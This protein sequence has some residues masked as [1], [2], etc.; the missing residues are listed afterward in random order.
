MMTAFII[1]RK[2]H[3]KKDSPQEEKHFPGF[4]FLEQVLV[5]TFCMVMGDFLPGGQADMQ[6]AT[7]ESRTDSLSERR[8]H[9][10]HSMG[11]Q[12]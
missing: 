3:Q 11:S 1:S 6:S 4:E 5:R 8:L 12:K 2:I 9:R 7:W 10:D